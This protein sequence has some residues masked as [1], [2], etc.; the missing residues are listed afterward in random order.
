MV[1]WCIRRSLIGLLC[2][3]PFSW[4]LSL[5]GNWIEG[6]VVHGK[7]APDAQVT[8]YIKDKP[9]QVPLDERGRFMLG[10]PRKAP[11]TV[12]LQVEQQGVVMKHYF[13][14][15]SREYAVQR[16]NGL[17]ASKVSQFSKADL[18]RIQLEGAA[19]R[20]ARQQLL[21][22]N[23]FSE[24]FDWPVR[25][26]ISGV[27][28][29]QRILNG[30]PRRPHYGIDI[31]TKTGTVVRA[32][33]SGEVTFVHADLFFSGKTLILDHGL[34]VSSTFLHLHKTLVEVGDFV[35]RGQPI[36]EVGAT[37][38]VTGAH[39]DWRANWLDVRIDPV[40]LLKESVRQYAR[41]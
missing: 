34:G 37:G 26:R 20:K 21:D 18:R 23:Y 35:E 17:P 15:Q 30:K 41:P 19:V 3:A 8:F 39:L 11:D 33:A 16:I 38:R 24:G 2:L 29:S 9:Y 22:M 27:Y 13:A 5:S 28:G 7:V 31:A 36:A 32:P 4:A 25:G 6:G 14:V 1:V 10:L 40:Y 12:R